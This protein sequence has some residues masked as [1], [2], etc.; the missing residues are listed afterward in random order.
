MPREDAIERLTHAQIFVFDA[1]RGDR[2]ELDTN[3]YGEPVLWLAQDQI[4]RII[5]G[6]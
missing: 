6:R 3:E 1:P 5:H 4:D 2:L